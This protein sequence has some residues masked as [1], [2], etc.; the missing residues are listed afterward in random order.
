MGGVK[1]TRTVPL[2]TAD[3]LLEMFR[4]PTL[5]KMDVEGAE[6]EVFQAAERLLSEVRPI[7][8]VEVRAKN[9][10]SFAALARKHRYR[11]FDPS[12]PL[13]LS[14]MELPVPK[15]NCLAIPD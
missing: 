14:R 9:Q 7:I 2:V 13:G 15:F 11:M 6:M 8:Y 5:W 4:P 3:E 10:E 1:E 12:E